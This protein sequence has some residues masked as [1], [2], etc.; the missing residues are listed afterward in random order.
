MISDKVIGG[1]ASAQ[2]A[3]D[4]VE[5]A[6][7]G[8]KRELKSSQEVVSASA[9]IAKREHDQQ[10]YDLEVQRRGIKDAQAQEDARRATEFQARNAALTDG[11]DTLLALVGSRRDLEGKVPA[12]RI[13]TAAFQ[14]HVAKI[15]QAA[16][17]KGRGQAEAAYKVQKQLDDANVAKD[18]ALLR[19]ENE[20]L[21]LANNALAKQN[22]D[23]L[24][25]QTNVVGQMK[26]ISVSALNAS[27]GVQRAG[28][29][30]LG[31]AAQAGAQAGVRR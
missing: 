4:K 27:A 1:L 11:E 3:I 25:Q 13:L 31:G 14:A 12:G 16:E 17:G 2:A 22:A 21:K 30:A 26:D 5:I 7:S 8:L 18:I 29:D 24:A 9:E 20:Q 28:M 10:V 23:L 19:Q 15:E 6:L